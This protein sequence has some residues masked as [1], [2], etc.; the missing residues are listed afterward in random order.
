LL[1]E[2]GGGDKL[3]IA[4]GVIPEQHA[5][6]VHAAGYQRIFTMGADTRDIVQFIKDWQDRPE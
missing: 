1:R 6:A 3:L 4:G 5:P 2:K